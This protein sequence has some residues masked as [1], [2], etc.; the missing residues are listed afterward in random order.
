MPEQA[1]TIQII[2]KTRVLE[3]AQTGYFLPGAPSPAITVPTT[4]YV[5]KRAFPRNLLP[6]DFYQVRAGHPTCRWCSCWC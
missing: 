1:I 5:T 2:D 6:A 4:E 3:E